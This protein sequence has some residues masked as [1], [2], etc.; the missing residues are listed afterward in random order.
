MS[1]PNNRKAL[2]KLRKDP[3][4]KTA[5]AKIKPIE[6]E[7][8]GNVF[9]ELVK[10]IVYQ[11]ISFKA[12]DTIYGRFEDLVGKAYLPQ[13]L[14]HYDIEAFRAV[15]FS[16]QKA[17]Y[18][19]NI[20]RYFKDE[21]LY[22]CDWSQY[23]DEEIINSLTTIKGVGEWTA[24]MI[25]IFELHRPDVLPTKDLAIQ[26]VMQEL[27]G[28]TEEKKA[29]LLKMEEVAEQWQPYRTLATLYLY[30]WKRASKEKAKMDKAKG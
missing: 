12:A 27:Y 21:N 2:T 11:Q 1:I 19:L 5:M 16:K 20:A 7:A 22:D 23:T 13:D 17:T 29:L 26:Q 14:L 8:S 30:G 6:L 9:N 3:I 25:L 15:G 28:L 18:V 10:A 24:Q 4:F